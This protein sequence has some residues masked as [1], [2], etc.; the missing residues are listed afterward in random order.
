MSQRIL[1]I[2]W[3]GAEPS[4]ISQLTAAGRL[5]NLATLARQGSQRWIDST[6]RAESSIAWTTFATGADPGLHGIFGFTR[7]IEGS[8]QTELNNTTHVSLPFFWE[9][10]GAHGKRVGILNM[11]M[12]YPVRPV[13]GW[14]VSGLMTP[15]NNAV[16][17][18]PAELGARLLSEGYVID[19]DAMTN[20]G[21][22]KGFYAQRMLQ[23]VSARTQTALNLLSSQA[24]DFGAVIYTELDRLQHFFWA[25]MD[26]AHPSHEKEGAYAHVIHDHYD[27]LDHELGLLLN[28]TTPDDLV[29]VVSDHGFGPI[30]QRFNVNAWLAREGFL[31]FQHN[32]GELGLAAAKVMSALRHNRIAKTVKKSLFGDQWLIEGV[33]KRTHLDQINWQQT[34]AWFCETGGI[35]INLKGREPQGIVEPDQYDALVDAIMDGLLQLKEPATQLP[36]IRQV[37]K[38][39]QL[40]KGGAVSQAPDIIAAG[41]RDDGNSRRNAALHSHNENRRNELFSTSSPYTGDHADKAICVSNHAMPVSVNALHEVTDWIMQTAIGTPHAGD[42]T[43]PPRLV[44]PADPQLANEEDLLLRKRLKDLGYLD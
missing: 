41:F 22:Q 37:N 32:S 20:T 9:T 5:K 4:I 38:R 16:F 11:P 18:C 8:Y 28:I 29:I 40:Y 21:E 23:Q 31:R 24:W 43:M 36:V 19:A 13:N 17:T 14:F 30:S 27:A 42:I 44:S 15:G 1:V 3:D 12:S 34:K 7:Q 35:R 33:R 10:L 25:D 6:V 39:A 2:G 26:T